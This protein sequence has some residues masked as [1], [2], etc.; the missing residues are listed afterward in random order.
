MEIGYHPVSQKN[1]IVEMSRSMRTLYK[2]LSGI[3]I[4]VIA[5]YLL[6]GHLSSPA[7]AEKPGSLDTSFNAPDGFVRFNSAANNKDR[8]VDVAVQPDGKIVVLG[9]SNTSTNEDLLLARYNPDGSMDESFGTNGLV[10]YNGGGNDRGLG[11]ALQDDGKILATGYTTA[12]GQRNVLV[13]RYTVNGTPDTTF[14]TGGVVTYS[15]PGSGTDIGFG[16]AVAPDGGILVTGESANMTNQDALVLRYTP[17][18]SLDT[19]FGAGSAVTFGRAGLDR[20][21]AIAARP[22]GKVLVAG[23]TMVTGKDDVLLFR[24]T[25][26]G[27]VDKT[28]G[29]QGSVTYSGGGD[30]SDYGDCITLGAD[31][32]ILVSGATSNGRA[33]DVLLLRYTQDGTPDST[34]GKGGVAV[35]GDAGDRD[36][37]GYAHAVQQDGRIVLTGYA[38][39]STYDDVLVMRFDPAGQPDKTFG[40]GG[41]VTWNGPGNN[42]D[43]GQ[44]IALQPDGRILVVGF[45]NN[46]V[47]EDMLLMRFLA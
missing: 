45:S 21:F 33:F 35:F 5:G 29:Q 23:S 18:G 9:Y 39:N 22:D 7:P 16:I 42:T 11:L 34:F 17:D 37:Y 38:K 13:L 2:V 27:M 12:T 25:Q 36:E 20:G 46:G 44:G 31:G 40:T 4:V 47:N 28:F 10:L 15:S 19:R 8:A 1:T 41:R 14:G 3:V 26:E 30:Y 6:A 32:T 43:Y 24:L